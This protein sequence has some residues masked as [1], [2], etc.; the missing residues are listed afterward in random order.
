MEKFT[1]LRIGI[2]LIVLGSMG[3]TA[4]NDNGNSNYVSS[5]PSKTE[6]TDCMWQDAVSSK[7]GTGGTNA[8][9]YAY[10][11]S[12]VTY[13]SSEFTV[14]KGAKVFIEGDYPYARH[15][16]LVSYTAAGERVNSLLDAE[17]KPN[18]G[19][20]NPFVVGNNRL[21]KERGYKTELVLG[22]LP[23]SPKQNTLYA[24]KTDSNSVVLIYRVYVP[25]K[26]YNIKG[27]ADFPRYKVQLANGEIKTGS[28]VCSVLNVKKKA[29]DKALSLPL[30]QSLALYNKQ[31]YVGFPAQVNPTWYT[32]YN[33]PANLGCIYKYNMNQCEGFQ[34]VRKLNQW[35]TP[36]NEY[37]F[38]VTSRKL[39][40]VIVLKG[41][42]PQIAAT[43][44]NE[45][46]LARG[47]IR[48]WSIC[49]NE[50]ISTATNF[51]IYDEQIK[52]KDKD[53]FY[54]LVVSLPEDRPTNATEECGV[55]YLPLSERGDGY[56][57]PDAAEKGHNDLGFLIMRN[58][59]PYQNFNQAIQNTKVWGDE[60]AVMG[61]YLPDISYT[62]REDF[63]AKGCL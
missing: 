10:P 40:K 12:N 35:A 1:K 2:W 22:D 43:Y 19:V 54:T 53:G 52:H 16:S 56:T 41:K 28:D 36:D 15:M 59:L 7:D 42:L 9:N 23:V 46:T 57:G 38:S 3:L 44:E 18:D 58:L 5:Q 37:T 55:A 63:E 11:D 47:D 48:Y 30:E 32:A 8:M 17:I 49:T 60:K 34:T 4:C 13:W 61:E 51:C 27:G 50:L 6:L 21:N 24:P 20:I 29:L 14:P 62:S 26:G 33:G 31:S 45:A 39:G 25:N